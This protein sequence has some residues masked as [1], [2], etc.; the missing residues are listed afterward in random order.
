M[1]KLF[2]SVVLFVLFLACFGMAAQAKVGDVIGEALHTDIVVMINEYPIS[3]YAV[4]GQSVVVAED[5]RNFGIDVIWDQNTRSLTLVRNNNPKVTPVFVGKGYPTG[6]KYTDILETD[7]SVWAYGKQITSYAMNGCTMVPV[8]ELDMFGWITWH[9]EERKLFLHMDNLEQ[10]YAAPVAFPYYENTSIPNF[11]WVT[12]TF[13]DYVSVNNYS[14]ETTVTVSYD[15]VSEAKVMKYISYILEK[16]WYT[17]VQYMPKSGSGQSCR[18]LMDNP[19][20]Q[21]LIE[22]KWSP[23][24]NYLSFSATVYKSW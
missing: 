10:T 16:G 14:G 21:C 13:G 24:S 18:F 22:I 5:L 7:I 17:K 20:M 9:P 11:G 8:E 4:N 3:S 6:Q 2:L 12:E 19:Q 1:K 23:G 15:N